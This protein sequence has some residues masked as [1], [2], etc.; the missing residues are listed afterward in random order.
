MRNVFLP[1][2]P[3]TPASVRSLEQAVT[4]VYAAG[5]RVK[6]A[7]VL[8]RDDLGSVQTLFAQP[9]QYAAFL[10]IE[11]GLWYS[12]PLL[13]AMPSGF[14]IYDGGYSTKA[15]SSVL[16][17]LAVDGSTSDA[18]VRSATAAV[19]K[20]ESS[21]SLHSPDVMAPLVSVY[22]TRTKRGAV[23][24][25]RFDLYDDSGRARAVAR[26][27]EAGAQIATLSTPMTFALGTRHV[28]LRW[29]VPAT[30]RSR[31][32]QL[33][34]VATDAAGNTSKPTCEAFLRVS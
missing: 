9:T 28:A 33:C 10:G 30:L 20:L 32:L 17:S 29:R 4:G 26:V 21:G 34:V 18:L 3:P 1:Y 27:Y 14:G 12:G 19:R 7:I 5:D 13:V 15:E 16:G 22:A 6:V 31:R 23:A 8:A 2:E 24:K 25:L 11:L